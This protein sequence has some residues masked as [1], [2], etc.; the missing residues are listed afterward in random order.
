MGTLS[1]IEAKVAAA[2]K[3][4]KADEKRALASRRKWE[5]LVHEGNTRGGISYERL[6]VLSKLSRSRIDQVLRAVRR[7]KASN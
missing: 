7:R 4:M 5:N 1:D 2:A 6:A 3:E